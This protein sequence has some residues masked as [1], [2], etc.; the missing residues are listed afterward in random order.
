MRGPGGQGCDSVVEHWLSMHEDL[1][2]I[3]STIKGKNSD[4]VIKDHKNRGSFCLYTFYQY[5]MNMIQH[6]ELSAH[7]MVLF[8]CYIRGAE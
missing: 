1:G 5:Q 2:S 4:L 3:P 8:P 6:L 7:Y